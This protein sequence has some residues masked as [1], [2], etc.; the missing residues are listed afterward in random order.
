MA[1]QVARR[2]GTDVARVAGQVEQLPAIAEADLDLAHAAATAD[3]P[4]VDPAL[5]QLTTDG[6]QCP[7]QLRVLFE[8]RVSVDEGE[9]VLAEVLLPGERQL[10]TAAKVDLAG[11]PPQALLLV[12]AG[13]RL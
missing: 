6:G 3:E 8:R 9:R 13:M 10:R 4:V 11:A 2:V 7:A 1:E 5:V 12:R